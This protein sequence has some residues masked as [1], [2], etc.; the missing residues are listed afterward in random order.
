MVS[1]VILLTNGNIKNVKLPNYKKPYDKVITNKFMEKYLTHYESSQCTMVGKWDIK[2]GDTLVA[3]GY[4]EGYHENNHEL[5]PKNKIM[6]E[7]TYGDILIVKVNDAKKMFDIDCDEYEKIYKNMFSNPITGDSDADEEDEEE[8]DDE[9]G[10]NYLDDDNDSNSDDN[11]EEENFV[12]YEIE[13][14]KDDIEDNIEDN[15]DE[16]IEKDVD[17]IEPINTIDE[18]INTTRTQML[19]IFKTVLSEEMATVLEKSTFK[20]T[21]ELGQKRNIIVNWE[22]EIFKKMYINKSRS[23]YSN[24]INKSNKDL[25]KLIKNI[26]AMPFMSSQEI[27]PK[28]WKELMDTKYKR[29][30]YLY[31]E[32]QEA[33]T[34]QFKCGRC[35]SRECTYYELQTRSAD[36]AMTTFITCLTCGN[37]WKQ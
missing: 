12:D 13:P 10:P 24:I 17:D 14:E 34:D 28:H 16:P 33:M 8:D 9:D 31:E 29:D 36:E 2:N 3:Y 27:F 18:E 20:Y 6:L 35:K 21:I 32:K 5:P 23:M 7:L 25:P 4:I 11:L 19:D 15:I 37:R 26:E 1:S 30:K 22:N